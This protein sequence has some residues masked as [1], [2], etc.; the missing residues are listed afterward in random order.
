MLFEKSCCQVRSDVTGCAGEKDS[1]VA[2]VPLAS[3]CDEPSVASG[4]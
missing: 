3:M 4:K 2:Q 1:H